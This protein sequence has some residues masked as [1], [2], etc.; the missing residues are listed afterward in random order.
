MNSD[1]L[2]ALVLATGLWLG[3]SAV[4]ISG[5][6]PSGNGAL[7]TSTSSGKVASHPTLVRAARPMV[8]ADVQR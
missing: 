8:L 4:A 3:L 2:A 6:G 1:T 7:W 5:S